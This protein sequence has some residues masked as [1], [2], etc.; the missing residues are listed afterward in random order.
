MILLITTAS[1]LYGPY[2]RLVCAHRKIA[3][4]LSHRVYHILDLEYGTY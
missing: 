1:S 4:L 3:L 2:S